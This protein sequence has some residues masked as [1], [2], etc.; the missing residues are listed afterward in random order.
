[1][2]WIPL[3]FV[4]VLSGCVVTSEPP[5]SGRPTPPATRPKAVSVPTAADKQRFEQVVRRVE[6]MAERMCRERTSGNNCDFRIV[7]DARPNQPSNAYQTF[8]KTG[9]PVLAFTLALIADVRNQDE[10]AFVMSHEAAHHIRGHA[11]RT[12][13][14]AQ[15]GALILGGLAALT[16]AGSGVIQEAVNMGGS[17]GAR[18]YSKD[19]ELE[20]DALGTVITKRAGFDPVRGAQYFNRIPD[21]GNRFLGTHPPNAQRIETVKRVNAGL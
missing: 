6:P 16:G 5:T 4:A 20:A 3:V 8:D 10:M 13:Q 17:V 12:Q 2:R 9:R 18:S 14:N 21:P 19:F 11:K 15:T 7:V 1:M